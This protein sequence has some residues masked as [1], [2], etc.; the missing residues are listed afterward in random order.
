MAGVPNPPTFVYVDGYN[1]YRGCL[2][3]SHYRWLDLQALCH[4]LLPNHD[5]QRIRFF[6]AHVKGDPAAA[7]R[8]DVYLRALRSLPVVQIHDDGAFLAHTVI[9]PL[10]DQP[11]EKMMAVLE[12][13]EGGQWRALRRPAA[14]HHVRASVLNKEEKGSDVNLAAYLLVDAFSKLMSEAVVISGDSDLQTPILL[15]KQRFLPVRVIN[16]TSNRPSA[17]LKR[18]ASSYTSLP[19]AALAASQLPDPVVLA[20]GTALSKPAGW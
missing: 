2:K 20:E 18:A 5:V 16:P 7:A 12:F 13:L 9:R 8:Q 6:T 10:A 15:T 11:H 4:H 3:D 1:L 14:R 17:E 19:T